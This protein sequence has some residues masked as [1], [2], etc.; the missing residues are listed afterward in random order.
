VGKRGRKRGEG[1]GADDITPP[2][3]GQR[4]RKERCTRRQCVE[5]KKGGVFK[6]VPIRIGGGRGEKK[7]RGIDRSAMYRKKERLLD[8]SL[9]TEEGKRKSGPPR[10][11][12]R[13]M[14]DEKSWNGGTE[15]NK[16]SEKHQQRCFLRDKRGGGKRGRG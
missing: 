6:E 16:K 10:K 7:R 5:R 12:K 2:F 4:G 11:G 15:G 1:G 14:Q 13:R 3:G 8:L 9:S